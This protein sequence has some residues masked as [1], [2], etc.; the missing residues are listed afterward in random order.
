MC[1]INFDSPPPS[2]SYYVLGY[3]VDDYGNSITSEA[4]GAAVPQIFWDAFQARGGVGELGVG[5]L[6][7]MLGGTFFCAVSTTT[8][9]AR[10]V[11]NSHFS[12]D[13]GL[14]NN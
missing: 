8:C 11:S 1:L 2:R 10:C 5:F 4:G 12:L 6:I 9:I 14:G 3:A 13:G 7:I